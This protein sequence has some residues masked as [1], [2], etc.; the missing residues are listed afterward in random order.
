MKHNVNMCINNFKSKLDKTLDEIYAVKDEITHIPSV[1]DPCVMYNQQKRGK[2]V[3]QSRKRFNT[4]DFKI[5][6]FDQQKHKKELKNSIR[7][8]AE[9]KKA[10][11]LAK[12]TKKI[13]VSC[14]CFCP[15][16]KRLV[17]SLVD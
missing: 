6:V 17:I 14:A 2:T 8:K 12:Q 3:Q 15:I 7:A 11:N 1:G 13:H 5:S 4:E 9:K 16:T 10:E